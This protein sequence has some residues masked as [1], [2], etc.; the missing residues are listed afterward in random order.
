[1]LNNPKRRFSARADYIREQ[2]GRP[3]AALDGLNILTEYLATVGKYF[4][5]AIRHEPDLSDAP[6]LT[7]FYEVVIEHV[8]ECLDAAA[9]L[10]DGPNVKN[11]EIFAEG[12]LFELVS[13]IMHAIDLSER[14]ASREKARKEAE[15][16]RSKDA[17]S[18]RKVTATELQEFLEEDCA[19]LVLK[20]LV[21]ALD[22]MVRTIVSAFLP[23]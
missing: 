18:R 23:A 7:E 14:V 2:P 19:F 11:Q 16:T 10:V 15:S 4:Q 6:H 13:R 17:A 1:M 20:K 9:S 5:P 12:Q 3:G 8:L 22:S 21:K